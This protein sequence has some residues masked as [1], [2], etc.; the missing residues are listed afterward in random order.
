MIEFK[1]RDEKWIFNNSDGGYFPDWMIDT[2]SVDFVNYSWQKHEKKTI[3]RL[4]Y[5]IEIIKAIPTK[6]PR[7]EGI[8][9]CQNWVDYIGM[10]IAVIGFKGNNHPCRWVDNVDDF[11]HILLFYEDY[12]LIGFNSRSFDDKLLAAHGLE[13]TATHY[14]LLEQ[15]RIAAGFKAHFQSVPRGYSYKLDALAKANGMAKTE[16]GA[17]APVLWQQG[18][19]DRVREYCK[20]DV[21]ITAAILDLGLAGELIDPNTS[22]KLQLASL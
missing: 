22:N 17:M 1:E 21:E 16:N 7:I 3:N 4:I 12:Q 8:E 5:D 9:Y 20:V 19:R 18:E 10:G 13:G 2:N 14:D 6:E 15:I 11:K